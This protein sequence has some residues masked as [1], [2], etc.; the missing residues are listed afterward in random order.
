MRV[1]FTQRAIDDLTDIFNYI[2]QENPHA[3]A[4]VVSR[5]E[6]VAA[7]LGEVPGMG[8]PTDKQG[9]QRFPVS[10]TRYLIF[11]EIF[12]NEVVIVHIR[13]GA[14]RPWAGPR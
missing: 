10:R 7:E 2:E 6:T 3:A 9:I 11:Y 5:I 12:E 4:R 8:A 14:R 1:R 13:H